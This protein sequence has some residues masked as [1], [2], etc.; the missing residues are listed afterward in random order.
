MICLALPQGTGA[1]VCVTAG[2]GAKRYM[3]SRVPSIEHEEG[4]D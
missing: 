1:R 2:N 3:G 4:E